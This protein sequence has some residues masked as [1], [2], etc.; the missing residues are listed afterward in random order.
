M[1]LRSNHLGNI[2][3]EQNAPNAKKFRPNGEISPNLVTL[4]ACCLPVGGLIFFLRMRRVAKQV[5]M[6]KLARAH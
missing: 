1:K 5:F 6:V 4:A 3:S 2:F